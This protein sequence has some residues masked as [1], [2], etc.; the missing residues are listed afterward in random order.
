MRYFIYI[1]GNSSKSIYKIGFCNKNKGSEKRMAEV[2]TGCPYKLEIFNQFETKYGSKLEKAIHRGFEL[3]KQ[4]EIDG[5]PLNG[6]WFNLNKNDLDNF[7]E[8]CKKMEQNFDFIVENS[9]F[10]DSTKLIK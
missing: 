3:K 5:E 8:M 2:Q 6:E 1:F 7:N 10:E 9:T 4:C